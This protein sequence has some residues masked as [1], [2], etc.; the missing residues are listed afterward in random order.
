[1][2]RTGEFPTTILIVTRSSPP[3]TRRPSKALLKGHV[4]AVD[5]LNDTPA[6]EKAAVS[7]PP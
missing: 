2:G 7:T 4:E 3:S 1:M 6:A 5:W